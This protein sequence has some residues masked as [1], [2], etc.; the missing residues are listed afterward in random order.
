MLEKS[1][2]TAIFS[3]FLVFFL[4]HSAVAALSTIWLE[5]FT[6]SYSND[7]KV[8]TGNTVDI[9]GTDIYWHTS[10]NSG[11]STAF[12]VDGSDQLIGKNLVGTGTWE[13]DNRIS[14]ADY[15]NV[16]ISI[17]VTNNN[18]DDGDYIKLFYFFEDSSVW[19]VKELFNGFSGLETLTLDV[20]KGDGYG[21]SLLIMIE[22]LND[23]SSE[24]YF[25][26]NV[27][28]TGVDAVP[29]PT[30]LLLLGS[31]MVGLVG[32]RRKNRS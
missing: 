17:D 14:I 24:K 18:V 10:I 31:G 28:V 4:S 16:Q 6:D 32:F 2:K 8:A 7:G 19:G 15:K 12:L 29:I 11:G 21:D 30:S 5:D 3:F 1:I 9:S 27:M 25:I 20:P 23:S 22:A 13:T 26:D